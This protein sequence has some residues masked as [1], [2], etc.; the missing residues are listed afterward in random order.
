MARS[1]RRRAVPFVLAGAC[2]VAPAFASAQPAD[3]VPRTPWGHPDLQ[4]IWDYRTTTPLDRPEDQ[5][6]AVLAE[7]A[8]EAFAQG[9]RDA[10]AARRVQ[11]LNADWSDKWDLGLT[12]GRTALI[13]DPPS[14]RRPPLTAEAEQQ[15][16]AGSRNGRELFYEND[17]Q[18]WAVEIETEPTADW[19]DPVALFETPWL[20]PGGGVVNYN[21]TLD[22][23][24]FVFVQPIEEAI[25]L[26]QINVVLNWFQELIERVPVN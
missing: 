17:G 24:R 6:A 23:Q 8:A 2:L 16:L 4:G 15:R 11:T 19:E 10:A 22:G 3:P 9:Q 1:L 14:G 13:V 25:E 18:L 7:E 12:G 26:R 21:V 20:I 5:G